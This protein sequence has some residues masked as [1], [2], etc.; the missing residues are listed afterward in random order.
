MFHICFICFYLEF[1]TTT[2]TNNDN[3]NN[4]TLMTTQRRNNNS[5]MQYACGTNQRVRGK[6]SS[7]NAGV[8]NS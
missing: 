1:E 4:S 6:S 8:I 7:S 5:T 2:T 3:N